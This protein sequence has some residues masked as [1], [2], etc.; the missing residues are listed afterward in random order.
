MGRHNLTYSPWSRPVRRAIRRTRLASS[1]LGPIA[2]S[3]YCKL[4]APE[5]PPPR[6]L[7]CAT[8]V[9]TVP[10]MDGPN[11]SMAGRVALVTGAGRGI[12][13]GIAKALASA[14]CAVAIQDIEKDVALA[15]AEAINRAG[16]RAVALGGDITDLG[17]APRVITQ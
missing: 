14:E 17:L 6:R 1:R 3:L 9:R 10:G 8:A 13:L 16:G 4:P 12:G 11:F 2:L 5:S 7:A 15:E